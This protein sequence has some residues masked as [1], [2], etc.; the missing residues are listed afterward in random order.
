MSNIITVPLQ[1]SLP[2][3]QSASSQSEWGKLLCDFLTESQHGISVLISIFEKNI[4]I[5]EHQKNQASLLMAILEECVGLTIRARNIMSTPEEKEKFQK[6]ISEFEEWFRI[7]LAKLD[8]TVADSKFEGINLMNGG[9]LVTPLDQKGQSKLVTEGLILTTS[10]LGIR[11]PDFS[12]LFSV[13]NSRIDVM[14]AMDMVV[15]IRNIISSHIS[16]LNIGL[17]VAANSSK[18]SEWAQ[19]TLAKTDLLSEINSLK[20]LFSEGSH[21]LGDEP[22]AEPSQQETLNNFASSPSMEDI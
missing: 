2:S 8:K 11:P 19:A 14:N 20:K 7:A 10:E 9:V 15:T 6:N 4:T 1:K 3:L 12:N 5:L 18:L 13:Q 17:E 22:L 16:T 21:I